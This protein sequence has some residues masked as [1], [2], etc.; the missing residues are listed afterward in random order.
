MT[1]VDQDNV[2]VSGFEYHLRMFVHAR[3]REARPIGHHLRTANALG[4]KVPLTLSRV[5]AR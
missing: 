1:P 5:P 2:P 3:A 4:L